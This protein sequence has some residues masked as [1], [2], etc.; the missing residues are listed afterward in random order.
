MKQFTIANRWGDT[1]RY[2]GIIHTSSHIYFLTR[3][4]YHHSTLAVDCLNW[5]E[6]GKKLQSGRF[7]PESRAGGEPEFTVGSERYWFNAGDPDVIL[8][9]PVNP[10]IDEDEHSYVTARTVLVPNQHRALYQDAI[11]FGYLPDKIGWVGLTRRHSPQWNYDLMGIDVW[12]GPS[13]G[14]RY[15]RSKMYTEE[16]AIGPSSGHAA[17]VKPYI[18]EHMLIRGLPD[19]TLASMSL[20][21]PE[22]DTVVL[23]RLYRPNPDPRS[24][25]KSVET[26]PLTSVNITKDSWW[27]G[28][29]FAIS[30]DGRL[31]AVATSIG[32]SL[33]SD[34]GPVDNTGIQFFAIDYDNKTTHKLCEYNWP[35]FAVA[36]SPDGATLA[37]FGYGLVNAKRGDGSDYLKLCGTLTVMDID[38]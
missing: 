9:R 22:D 31:L 36:F 32:K 5:V 38:L 7:M 25:E 18:S 10:N 20:H 2:E 23:L 3:S 34:M 21:G 11:G 24:I 14:V 1:K 33:D 27:S 37:S 12:L 30:P 29:D 28:T 8:P 26:Y 16:T 35:S 17:M 6:P 19:G 13:G 15:A 4:K